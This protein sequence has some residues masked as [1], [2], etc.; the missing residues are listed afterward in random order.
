MLTGSKPS[1]NVGTRTVGE[2]ALL[3]L[4]LLLLQLVNVYL[5][6]GSQLA[7]SWRLLVV[8]FTALPTRFGF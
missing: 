1:M 8:Q 4:L 3:L 2:L 7:P 5:V 6:F